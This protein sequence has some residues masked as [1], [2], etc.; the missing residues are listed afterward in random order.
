VDAR[1]GLSLLGISARTLMPAADQL[2]DRRIPV[3]LT[4]SAS[5]GD[6]DVTGARIDGAAAQRALR[7]ARLGRLGRGLPSIS[8]ALTFSDAG[9]TDLGAPATC[10]AG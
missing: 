8:S 6:A 2:K 9:R 10:A 7:G 1:L 4:L 3:L 5:S